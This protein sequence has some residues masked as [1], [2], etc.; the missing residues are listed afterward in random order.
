MTTDH[1][2]PRALEGGD[3]WE[4]LVCACPECNARKGSRTP[5]QARMTLSR[6]PRRPNYFTFAVTG[7]SEVPDAWR[8]YLFLS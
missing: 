7:M 4:N 5:Q 3:S 8:Q 6:R 1:V 2:V